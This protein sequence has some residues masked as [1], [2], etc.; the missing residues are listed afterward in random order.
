MKTAL[1]LLVIAL[2]FLDGWTTYQALKRGGSELSRIEGGR[3]VIRR[4]MG[5]GANRKDGKTHQED[6]MSHY[7][8]LLGLTPRPWEEHPCN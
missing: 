2:Q 5:G 6:S 7:L 4:Q 3:Q 1:L 8:L